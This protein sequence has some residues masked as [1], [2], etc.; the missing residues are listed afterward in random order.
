[1]T[2]VYQASQAT[3]DAA[4]RP[5]QNASVG[6]AEAAFHRRLEQAAQRRS[7]AAG[8]TTSLCESDLAC[9]MSVLEQEVL[10]R[11]VSSYRPADGLRLRRCAG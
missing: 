7:A 6:A 4:V 8:W 2:D 10:P 9:L 11:L 3:Q 5:S 1:M